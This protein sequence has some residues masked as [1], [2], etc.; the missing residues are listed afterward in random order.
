MICPVCIATA[1]VVATSAG[2]GGGISAAVWKVLRRK[3][4][5]K[6]EAEKSK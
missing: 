1:A 5:E 6:K 4:G 3:W 2:S